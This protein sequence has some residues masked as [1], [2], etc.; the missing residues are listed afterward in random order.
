MLEAL[1]IRL[2]ATVPLMAAVRLMTG[3]ID[4]RGPNV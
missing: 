4:I 3:V 1:L 2:T